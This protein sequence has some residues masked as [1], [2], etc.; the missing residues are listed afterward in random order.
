MRIIYK[1]GPDLF[2]VDWLTRQNHGENKDKKMLIM[3]LS[4]NAI[5]STTSISGCIIMHEIHE[6][7]SQDKCIQCLMEYTIQGWPEN[8]NQL[9]QDIRTY[10]VFRDDWQLSMVWS[11]K[12][13]I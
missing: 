3:W 12:E 13:D 5:H 4:I 2:I 11:S 1:P 9:P 10:Y 8:K 6:A 7:T